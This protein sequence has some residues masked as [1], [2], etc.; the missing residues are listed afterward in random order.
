LHASNKDLQNSNKLLGHPKR[1]GGEV[2]LFPEEIIEMAW[3]FEAEAIADHGNIPV[4]MF[5]KGLCLGEEASGDM[6]CRGLAGGLFDG[7]VQVIDM[8]G[9]LAGV[10]FGGSQ[11]KLLCGGFD[12]EL[13]FQEFCEDGGDPGIGIGMVILDLFRLHLQCIMYDLGGIVPEEIIFV[14]IGGAYLLE[15]FPEDLTDLFELCF[16][17]AV[18]G[19]ASCGEHGK[20]SKAFFLDEGFGEDA[21]ES[22]VIVQDGL[23]GIRDPGIEEK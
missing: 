8:N 13:S 17:Q 23:I 7:P 3:F 1:R 9:E 6:F 14:N 12:G 2:G 19:I 15:H 20:V 10:V 5:E 4:G 22:G 21:E 18:K 16:F 11:P